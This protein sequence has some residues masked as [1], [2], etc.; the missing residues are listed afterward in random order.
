MVSENV[1]DT[2]RCLNGPTLG[3]K[4]HEQVWPLICQFVHACANDI[5][6]RR[7]D[8]V[9][10]CNHIGVETIFYPLKA[11]HKFGVDVAV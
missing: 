4:N 8:G 9:D 10:T 5:I 2:F 3:F 6:H 7:H 1:C 11:I